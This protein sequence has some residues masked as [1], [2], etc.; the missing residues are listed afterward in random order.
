MTADFGHFS[1]TSLAVLQS[2]AIFAARKKNLGLNAD[3]HLITL[4]S[5]NI[6]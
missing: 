1:D 4:V 5:L 2:F 6:C 3:I